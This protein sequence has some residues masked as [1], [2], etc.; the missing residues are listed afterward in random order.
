MGIAKVNTRAKWAALNPVLLAGETAFETDTKGKKIGDGKTQWSQ[1]PYNGGAGY[2]G[3]FADSS[4]QTATADTPTS[5]LF[6]VDDIRNRGVRV[7][8]NS[9][10]TVDYPGIY[11]FT[12]VLQ[13]SNNDTVIHDVHVWLRLNDSGSS[14]DLSTT[15]T[16][17]SVI[18]SHG[19][20]PGNNV[21]ALNHAM[22]LSAG[23]YVELI[24]ATS[25][26]DTYLQAGAAITSPYTRPATPSAHCSVV[27]IASA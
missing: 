21:A 1:L 16:K 26:I 18:E 19:G 14:G 8:S 22:R 3:D 23:D 25:H 4:S 6:R 7:V 17:V 27:Q 11:A 12:F 13:L 2:W 15:G 9:R 10:I 20:I 5:V 24:W